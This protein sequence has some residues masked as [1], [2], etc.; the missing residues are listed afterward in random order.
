[1][2][3]RTY[4]DYNASAPIRP[5]VF[6]VM[7]EVLGEGGNPTSIHAEGRHMRER[8]EAARD[9]VAALV[10]ADP[11]NV[12]FTSGGT[13]ANM[14]ALAPEALPGAA[15]QD[16][17]CFVSAI[18]HPSALCG[19]RFDAA[20]ISQIA[21]GADGVVDIEKLT[22]QLQAYRAEFPDRP[23]MAAVMLANNETGAIQPI[24]R[25]ADLV[26]DL[27]GVLHCD[28]VQ[29]AGKIDIDIEAL[30]ADMIALSAHKLGGPQGVGALVLG[31]RLAE[32]QAPLLRGGG[33]EL[34]RRAGT[35]NVA[36][37]AGFGV[38]AEIAA[39]EIG[40]LERVGRL[41]DELEQ[42]TRAISPEQ[43]VFAQAAPRLANTSCFA[44]SG[45][46][47]ET[48]VI[49]LDLEGVAVSAGS[50]C[51][52]GKVE[53]SHVLGAMGVEDSLA[54]CAI[55]VSLGW[56]S[57]AADIARFAEAWSSIARRRGER[58]QAA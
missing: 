28:C 54:E 58:R 39:A 29:A 14:T 27:G 8:V 18:E 6:G 48:S 1:M 55:R 2:N 35:E 5:Q 37:I 16:A 46:L 53:R 38:A 47:A 44:V 21:V 17:H 56:N 31:E 25:I 7:A 9:Q 33:Q 26:H 45:L 36:G 57:Q 32:F 42:R 3:T 20:R 11:R 40:D 24:A 15:G 43:V 12:I 4:L 52:S 41:R 10:K 19:G 49:G 13:E 23:F 50:A 30:G 51:S 22:A 34:R